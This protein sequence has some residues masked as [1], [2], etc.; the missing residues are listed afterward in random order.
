M[1]LAST[2]G[3][4]GGRCSGSAANR[5]QAATRAPYP[6]GTLRDASKM[7]HVLLKSAVVTTPLA[8]PATLNITATTDTSATLGWPDVDGESGYTVG[9]RMGLTGPRSALGR[10]VAGTTSRTDAS[11]QP[12]VR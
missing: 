9:R 1:V 3:R 10:L 12:G 6:V 4:I 11:L 7:H 8:A 2:I 5:R